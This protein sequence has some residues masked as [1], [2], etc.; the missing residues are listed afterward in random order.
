M[1]FSSIQ[2]KY[3]ANN[4]NVVNNDKMSQFNTYISN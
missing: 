1:Y 2:E 3:N 4:D